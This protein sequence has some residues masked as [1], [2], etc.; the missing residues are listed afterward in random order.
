MSANITGRDGF[1]IMRALVMAIA[2]IPHLPE[3]YQSIIDREDMLKLLRAYSPRTA[4]AGPQP[5]GRGYVP[6]GGPLSED[7][8][9]IRRPADRRNRRAAGE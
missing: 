6:P 8:S 3:Q 5:G 9:P 1:I 2:V 4:D 7:L